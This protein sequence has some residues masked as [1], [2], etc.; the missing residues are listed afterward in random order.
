MVA[1]QPR[2]RL[3]ER[4]PQPRHADPLPQHSTDLLV[5]DVGVQQDRQDRIQQRLAVLTRL[6]PLG[7]LLVS[8]APGPGLAG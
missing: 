2:L 3:R 1:W 7:E 4:G 8:L 5:G 6:G